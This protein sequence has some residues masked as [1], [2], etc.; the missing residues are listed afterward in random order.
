MYAG[1]Y[2]VFFERIISEIL[3]RDIGASFATS[4]TSILV[5]S[6]RIES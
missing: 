3:A 6:R 2:L 4:R 5:D 1:D